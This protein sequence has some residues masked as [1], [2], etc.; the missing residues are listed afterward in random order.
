MSKFSEKYSILKNARIDFPDTQLYEESF[1]YIVGGFSATGVSRVSLPGNPEDSL[2]HS[3]FDESTFLR[4]AVQEFHEPVLPSTVLRPAKELFAPHRKIEEVLPSEE[5]SHIEHANH[6]TQ[7]IEADINELI[8]PPSSS[9]QQRI[10]QLL[11]S[12]ELLLRD[13]EDMGRDNERQLDRI[14]QLIASEKTLRDRVDELESQDLRS[15]KLIR[16]LEEKLHALQDASKPTQHPAAAPMHAPASC[17]DC[18]KLREDN[19]DLKKKII[20]YNKEIENLHIKNEELLKQIRRDAAKDA[21]NGLMSAMYLQEAPNKPADRLAN[22]PSIFGV[23]HLDVAGSE[24]DLGR[25]QSFM[26]A[27][28]PDRHS[29]IEKTGQ[30]GDKPGFQP[31]FQDSS[32]QPSFK[33]LVRDAPSLHSKVTYDLEENLKALEM[34]KTRLQEVA[35]K[36]FAQQHSY[37]F[38]MESFDLPKKKDFSTPNGSAAKDRTAHSKKPDP[39]SGFFDVYRHLQ[40]G[41]SRDRGP[42][43][44][45]TRT[46]DRRDAAVQRQ[47]HRPDPKP[48]TFEDRNRDFDLLLKSDLDYKSRREER[49]AKPPAAPLLDSSLE[50]PNGRKQRKS[51]GSASH[52]RYLDRISK[53]YGNVL[54]GDQESS[55]DTS[56]TSSMKRTSFS[57][58]KTALMN[59]DNFLKQ[60]NDRINSL[61]AK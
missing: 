27:F 40:E 21:T 20:M 2:N 61:V 59:T 44:Q 16:S 50:H 57:Q 7:E 54:T 11:R 19:K 8:D 14:S 47:S 18:L 48:A 13:I 58:D 25:N 60:I 31:H 55:H 24:A 6:H 34:T 26:S 52:N 1:K 5:Y 35:E 4:V 51:L 28:D 45:W 41:L 38:T 29:K 49:T 43:L 15:Q 22:S 53:L 32:K 17:E 23:S 3:K 30:P 12:N 33:A 46:D 56:F 37:H 36:N 42:D 10:D 39:D 9:Q